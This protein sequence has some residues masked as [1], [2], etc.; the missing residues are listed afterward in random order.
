VHSVSGRQNMTTADRMHLVFSGRHPK[1]FFISD[2]YRHLTA[3]AEVHYTPVTLN[4]FLYVFQT[5]LSLLGGN[6]LGKDGGWTTS[7]L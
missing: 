2:L 1:L 6:G 4:V 7:Q 3:I 5:S